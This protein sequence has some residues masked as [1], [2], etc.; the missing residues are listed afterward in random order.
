MF[1][2]LF[3]TLLFLASL[4]LSIKLGNSYV[5]SYTESEL[6]QVGVEAYHL[7]DYSAAIAAWEPA[8]TIYEEN[9]NLSNAAIV[10]ENLALAHKQLEETDIAIE[11]WQKAIAYNQ[12]I[13]EWQAVGKLQVELAQSYN[14]R[15]KLYDAIDILCGNENETDCLPNTAL[16][17]SRT[18]EDK[19]TEA[20]ALGVLGDTYRLVNDYKQARSYLEESLKI[21]SQL[22]D[23][24]YQISGLNSLGNVDLNLAKIN[25][26]RA[27]LAIQKGD[28]LEQ[29][30]FLQLGRDF[31]AKALRNWQTSLKIAAQIPDKQDLTTDI[32]VSSLEP[33]Y[34]IDSPNFQPKLEEAIAV[35]TKM[36]D[37]SKKVYQT[38][39]L[40]NLVQPNSEINPRKTNYQCLQTQNPQTETLLKQA[41][42]TAQKIEDDRAQS[43]ASGRLGHFYECKKQYQKA[44][45][46]TE[47]AI[48]LSDQDF[49]NQDSLY[50]WEWQ[51]ARLLEAENQ[52]EP[53]IKAYERSLNIVESIKSNLLAANKELE[54][55]FRTNIEPIY[56]EL[57]SLKLQEN[58]GSNNP[59]KLTQVIT[60]ID[61]LKIVELENYL[62]TDCVL[63]TYRNF[64]I[65][66]LEVLENSAVFYT[67][68]F[69]K[70]LSVIAV[71]PG[72]NKKS[73]EINI[74]QEELREEINE[75]RRGLERYR[76]L[77]YDPIQAQKLYNWFIAPF[78]ED[79]EKTG[80]TNLVF[81]NDGILRTIP[82]SALHDGNKF[83]IEKYAITTTPSLS[84]T[85]ITPQSE[86]RQ[87]L[88][89]GVTKGASVDGQNFPPLPSV[90]L[91]I[92]EIKNRIPTTK[93]LVDES[94][95]LS[96]L[97]QELNQIPYDTIHI[98]T[99][100]QFSSEPEK[101][102]L[103]TGD[104]NKITMDDLKELLNTFS[105]EYGLIDLLALT[106]C[107]TAVGDD[108]AALGL[109]GISIES[110][111]K[112]VLASLWFIQDNSTADLVIK[113]YNNLQSGLS[114]SEALRLAQ[115]DM[116]NDSKY[117]HPAY[118]SPFIILGDWD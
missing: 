99:H 30:R 83:L 87:V 73:I 2:K 63:N 8:L 4:I 36:P 24:N 45:E 7:Q 84:L 74:N 109:A 105:E 10:A 116:I 94:F 111:A 112:T 15:G 71:F 97:Q 72:G 50:L 41:L 3:L 53:A 9:K 22:E 96:S 43:F 106:A 92:N 61:A 86:S 78:A 93:S 58:P 44:R 62:G 28:K 54:L 32:L 76:D 57:A 64:N 33:L 20:A 77:N 85:T 19:V 5:L 46:F 104:N 1:K 35:V 13:E 90:K 38:I 113:F 80:V 75:F 17:I 114:K 47:Q 98:A 25:Y 88:A 51:L 115:I 6:V 79:L 16:A 26:Y 34:R 108:R 29:E 82:M 49:K 40:A 118:W 23:V 70:Y 67:I 66:L 55:N 56:R 91:E 14:E 59:V 89:V 101:T 102:F 100:G 21:A 110:G 107:Q 95:S 65:E 117:S 31:D 42:T 48:L 103:V 60:V 52:T 68:I 37:S 12:T 39:E 18:Y 27:E 69:P 81:I 11:Y